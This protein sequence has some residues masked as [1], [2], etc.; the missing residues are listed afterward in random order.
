MGREDLQE[1]VE[2]RHFEDDIL[3]SSSC[4]YISKIIRGHNIR[5]H[6][7]ITCEVLKHI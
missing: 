1:C 2:L 6:W 7:S 3:C 5:I 4:V